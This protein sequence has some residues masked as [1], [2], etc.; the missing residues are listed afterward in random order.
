MILKISHTLKNLPPAV[1]IPLA[2]GEPLQRA[3]N[4]IASA[5]GTPAA[6]IEADFKAEPGEVQIVYKD[7]TRFFLL[8]LG[9][10]PAF[11][12]VLKAF[13]SLSGKNRQKLPA[14]IGISLLH[15]NLSGNAA[16]WVEA[17]LNGLA[18]GTYQIGRYK[19]I[20][21][22]NGHVLSGPNASVELLV[23]E[24]LAE[25]GQQAAR[26]GLAVAETQMSI[27]HLVNAPS[28]KKT[29]ESLAQWALE[30]GKKYGYS[31]RALGK[32]QILAEGLHAL[33]AVNR[34]S[35]YPP[36]FIIM[37][38]RP[39][40]EPAKGLKKIGL[41]GKGVT[42]DTGGLSIKPSANMHYMKSDMGGAAAV[43][44]TMEAAAK[45][46]LPVH[47]VGIVP[48]T[49]NSVDALSIK[50]SDVIDSYSGKTIE[51]ID[52]DAEGRLI[53]ADGLCYMARNY[54]PDTMID[55][56]TLTGSTVRTFGYH[57]AG[58]F[59]N[60][61]ALAAQ[62]FA[63]SER[64]GERSWRLPLWD[65]Y[66]DDIKSD[67]ADLRNFSGRPMAG[68]IGAAKFLE[69]FIE[70]HPAWAHLDIAGVAFNDSEFSSQKSATA[71]GVRLLLDYI[72]H[73]E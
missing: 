32:E 59:S 21:N 24:S 12:D 13:R 28:N 49:D 64:S 38:Y 37:E 61:D 54:R 6:L 72:S 17:A 51:V 10:S 71:F 57:A 18:L 14:A 58:L 22:G 53:L 25:K 65:A 42:F 36:A 34:G 68:A 66:K 60:N 33:L 8:G 48:S 73:L 9:Q 44:G 7:S 31:V 39:K 15:G 20:P 67:V 46:Q 23:E 45:L 2:A 50:P 27:F 43:F 56:A 40:K 26:R 16:I 47:L 35:E 3:L 29:P 19:K 62:L 41:V 30:S 52:T 1:I 11:Q 4:S 70:G 63:A 69:A 55:L 5:T